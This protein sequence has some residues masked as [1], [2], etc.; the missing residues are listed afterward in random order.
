[1]ASSSLEPAAPSTPPRNFFATGA[2][3]VQGQQQQQQA[4]K[5]PLKRLIRRGFRP[6]LSGRSGVCGILDPHAK[7]EP[8]LD[9][10]LALAAGELAMPLEKAS[11]RKRALSRNASMEEVQ[12]RFSYRRLQGKGDDEDALN[13]I[14]RGF[15]DQYFGSGAA[16]RPLSADVCRVAAARCRA[17]RSESMDTTAQSERFHKDWLRLVHGGFSLLVQGVG[18]KWR[19]LESFA[20]T[21]LEQAGFSVVRINAF[22]PSF[23]LTDGLREV[24]EQVFPTVPRTSGSAEALAGILRAALQEARLTQPPLAFL[25]HNLEC[26][27]PAHQAVLATIASTPGAHLIASVD[28][29]YAPLAWSPECL[30]NFRFSK[31]EYHTFLGYD[32]EHI[33]R[34]PGG[35]PPHTDPFTVRQ[36]APKASLGLVLRA[37]TRR[38]RELVQA[39]AEHQLTAGGKSGISAG[40]LFH[41]ASDLMIASTTTALRTL[42]NELRDHEVVQQ[43]AAA[44]GGVQ[45]YLTCD[46]GVLARLAD[47]RDPDE[48]DGSDAEGEAEAKGAAA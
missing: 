44:D 23:S 2:A 30:K 10:E 22:D 18:S 24:L 39:I 17:G 32:L 19:L 48:A 45:L 16:A 38:H 20:T 14:P 36:K 40:K 4:V 21:Q 34:F 11:S 47:G 27:A 25:V 1:M 43:R 7:K 28:N 35:L 6:I 33:T 12:N 5:S 13:L 3:A 41:R 31:E 46:Q 15:P 29:I 9:R 8:D 26:L 37:L 42:L